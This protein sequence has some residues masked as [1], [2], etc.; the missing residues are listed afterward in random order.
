MPTSMCTCSPKAR[1]A[2]HASPGL[3]Q[4]RNCRLFRLHESL[5]QNV[6]AITP[7]RFDI[8]NKTQVH[9][10]SNALAF[11]MKLPCVLEQTQGSFLWL[12]FKNPQAGHITK[13]EPE[14]QALL[15]L[16]QQEPK[17]GLEPATY[18]L[19]MY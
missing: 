15:R 16:N 7:K 2:R 10:I 11:Q 12:I 9:F 3:F 4:T 13:K 14:K 5:F 8:Y 18:S 19:R 17:A 1:R 6:F